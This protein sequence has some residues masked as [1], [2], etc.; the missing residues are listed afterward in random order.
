MECQVKLSSAMEATRTFHQKEVAF[1]YKASHSCRVGVACKY[2]PGWQVHDGER[3]KDSALMLEQEER[4]VSI[5]CVF[6][7][8]V[9]GP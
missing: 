7:Y 1:V 3:W 8:I 6:T 9:Y 4:G 5:K 2:M